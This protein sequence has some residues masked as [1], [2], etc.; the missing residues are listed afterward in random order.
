M[1]GG[2]AMTTQAQEHVAVQPELVEDTKGWEYALRFVFGGVVTA[3]V[4]VIGVTFGPVIAGMFL[5]FPA[6]LPATITLIENHRGREKAGVDAL[7]ASIGS[8]GLV[9]FG[10]MLWLLAPRSAGW[11]VITAATIVWFAVSACL[12][13]LIDRVRGRLTTISGT[14]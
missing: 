12:W 4:G 5:A 6:I 14:P 11:I 10:A 9:G 2:T 8:V 1:G 13:W 7:G 3:A